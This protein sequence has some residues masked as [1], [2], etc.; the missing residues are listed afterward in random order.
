[1]SVVQGSSG[2]ISCSRAMALICSSL[3]PRPFWC[4]R[5]ASS[6][7]DGVEAMAATRTGETG[8]RFHSLAELCPSKSPDAPCY[9]N[10]M[11]LV[12]S[13]INPLD[14]PWREVTLGMAGSVMQSKTLERSSN[15]EA[16]G[17]Y[18]NLEGRILA[19]PAQ[20]FII[21]TLKTIK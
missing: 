21:T 15:T 8:V 4:Q 19:S 20:F 1:M 16:K 2:R 14:V 12:S 7:F 17:A 5:G 18:D 9:A 10:T 6:S 13:W 3:S 11:K